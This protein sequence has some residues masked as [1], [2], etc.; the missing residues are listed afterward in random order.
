MGASAWFTDQPSHQPNT[1]PYPIRL[2]DP[3]RT[4]AAATGYCWLIKRGH[5]HCHTECT[6]LNLYYILSLS[7]VPN[8]VSL[9]SNL[10][11]IIHSSKPIHTVYDPV[12]RLDSIKNQTTHEDHPPLDHAYLMI[13]FNHRPSELDDDPDQ[14]P[15]HQI[16]FDSKPR[17]HQLTSIHNS[18]HP[19]SLSGFTRDIPTG[20]RFQ[21]D[22][23]LLYH[24]TSPSNQPR[25]NIS[26]IIILSDHQLVVIGS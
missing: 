7:F 8:Q 15:S 1:P 13:R 25:S 20:V 3:H 18:I 26:I 22:R 6:V 12:F 11:S 4:A 5:H 2:H 23:S 19:S 17:P 9:Q 10:H 16:S 24:H 14:Q 21:S